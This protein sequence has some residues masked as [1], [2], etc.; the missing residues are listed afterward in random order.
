MNGSSFSVCVHIL[1]LLSHFEGEYLSSDFIAQS[2]NMNPAMVRKEVAKLKKSGLVESREGKAGG[3]KISKSPK[4]ITMSEIFTSVQAPDS[5]IL[6]MYK[7]E[8]LPQCTIGS[9][10]QDK[11]GELYSEIDQQVIGKLEGISLY[12]FYKQF[13]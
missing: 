4:A 1:T 5:H 8:P 11:L 10:L 6:S 9:Q 2:I 7:N 3:S 13:I 12:D